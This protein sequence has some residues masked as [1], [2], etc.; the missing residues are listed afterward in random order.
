[1][2]LLLWLLMMS[3]YWMVEMSSLKFSAERSSSI[4]PL[5]PCWSL[6]WTFMHSPAAARFSGSSASICAMRS[7]LA[8][9]LASISSTSF[10]AL[11]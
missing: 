1:M 6:Y 9:I 7:S 10:E 5:V 8:A 4:R 11:S 2:A 3:R